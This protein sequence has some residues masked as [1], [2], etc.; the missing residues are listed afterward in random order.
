MEEIQINDLESLQIYLSYFFNDISLLR[1]AMTHRSFVNAHPESVWKHNERLEFLGDAVLNLSLSTI[2]LKIYPDLPEGRLSK[3][4]AGLV[5]EKKLATLSLKLGLGDY[6]LI[7]KGEERTG[8]REKPSL[9]ADTLEAVLGAIYLDGGFNSALIFVDRLFRPQF[10]VDDD[11]STQD[12]KT[13]LQEYCQG[14]LKTIPM[15]RV[16]REEGPDHKKIFFVEV[17]VQGQIISTGKGGTKKEAQQKA[18]EKAL[19]QLEQKVP[20]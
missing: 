16:F 3:I 10:T 15:Y 12:Y 5:N 4:R 14:N 18:A 6:L 11:L 13:L 20:G 17:I 19:V 8:G 7:G 9:L 1:Q 2:L